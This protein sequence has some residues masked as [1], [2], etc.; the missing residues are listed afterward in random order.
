[1]P[2]NHG[3]VRFLGGQVRASSAAF[4]RLLPPRWVT[5][6]QQQWME[7]HASLHQNFW[8]IGCAP[9]C[10]MGIGGGH[11]ISPRHASFVAPALAGT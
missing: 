1:M 3:Q 10:S 8:R 2:S 6:F 5:W 4:F 11:Y 9:V 7:V